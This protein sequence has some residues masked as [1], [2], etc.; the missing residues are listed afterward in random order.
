MKTT[1]NFKNNNFNK[2]INNDFNKT[3][4]VEISNKNPEKMNFKTA[5]SAVKRKK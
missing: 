1:A 4:N 5:I 3:I 2:T